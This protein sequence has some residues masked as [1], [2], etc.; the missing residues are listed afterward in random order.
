MIDNYGVVVVEA[1][2]FENAPKVV[3]YD[4]VG[5]PLGTATFT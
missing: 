4:P 3:E 2:V 5:V 1:L